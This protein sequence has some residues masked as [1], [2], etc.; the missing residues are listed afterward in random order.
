MKCH[1]CMIEIKR[2][3][4]CAKCT[5]ELFDGEKI[6]AKLDFASPANSSN[7]TLM[8][9]IQRISISGVQIKYSLKQEEGRL[10]LTN[11]G[12]QYILK[13]QPIGLFQNLDQAPAN[14]H[15]TMQIARQ[16]YK[17]K[18]AACSIVYFNDEITPAYLTR[19]FDVM[20]DGT[21]SQQEDFAQL[22]QINEH[23]AGKNYKYDYSYEEA[24]GLIKKH[25][26]SNQ[27]ELE[28]F[29]NLV[30]FNYLF[31]NGD[32]HLK[33]FSVFR[34][35][36]G[37]YQLTPAYDLMNTKIHIPDDS[38]LA[39]SKGLFKDDFETESYKA[40]GY[41]AYDDF[42]EFGKRIGIKESRLNKFIEGFTNSKKQVEDL[43][44]NSFLSED[45]KQKYFDLYCNK[46]NAVGY[47]FSDKRDQK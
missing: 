22:A 18:T 33:K 1:G 31:Q 42:H 23:N 13:P 17:I 7:E 15:L 12:G 26:A 29:F 38:D 35:K 27:V 4:F 46:L 45:A 39:L 47:S 44:R 32:A 5:Q 14:E 25:V 3:S 6:P 16:I 24:A 30:I 2:G 37:D 11:S 41:Y 43:V 34:T 8:K 36:Y 40:N 20:E 21:H 19:R 10:V 28:K 9:N